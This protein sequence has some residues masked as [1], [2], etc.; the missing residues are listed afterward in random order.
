ML[1]KIILLFQ[2]FFKFS[3]VHRHVCA[4]VVL[5]PLVMTPSTLGE[6]EVPLPLRQPVTY[7]LARGHGFNQPLLLP[8]GCLLHPANFRPTPV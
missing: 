4:C 1:L 6:S 5:P 3:S 7:Y 8:G 2:P